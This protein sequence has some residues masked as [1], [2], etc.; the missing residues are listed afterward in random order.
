MRAMDRLQGIQRRAGKMIKGLETM[1][2][3]KSLKELG[4]SRKEMSTNMS[5][6]ISKKKVIYKLFLISSGDRA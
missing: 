2:S 5:K 3:E 6:M 1:T 4:T